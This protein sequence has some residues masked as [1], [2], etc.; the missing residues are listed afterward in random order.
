MKT[1]TKVYNVYSFG[2]LSEKA[3]RKAIEN[4][5]DLNV[6]YGWWNSVYEDAE[7]VGIKITS[8]DIGRGESITGQFTEDALFTAFKIVDEHG[9]TCDTYQ[10]AKSFLA[11]RT[12]IIE[13]A[14]KDETGGFKDEYELDSLLNDIEDEFKEDLLYS[15]LKMLRE[16][17]EYQ[18]SEEAIIETIE[19][20]EYTF[21]EDGTLK[22]S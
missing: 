16:E 9:G 10:L 21:L 22:N 11:Q 12:S 6:D 19:C 18:T 20:N 17:Y 8:F 14:E 13:S 15:Y 1:I 2:E 4:L 3:K 5:Y 7:N